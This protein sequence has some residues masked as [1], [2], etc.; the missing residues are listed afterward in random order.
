MNAT[1]VLRASLLSLAALAGP[2]AAQVIVRVNYRPPET[3][4]RVAIPV[5]PTE[6]RLKV[7]I[8]SG[9]N[10]YEHDW[11]G[12]DNMLRTQLQDT[13]R[14][15]VRVTEDF[16]HGGQGN[17]YNDTGPRVPHTMRDALDLWEKSELAEAAFGAE[18]RAHY[19][20]Y[21]RVELAAFDSAV[22]DWE[23]QRSF[24]RL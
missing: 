17:A 20:N 12:V 9:Q 2:V 3:V 24:E 5:N 15:D 23:L 6:Q 16:D 11:T 8:I 13:G 22:T 7:L 14:F 10:S 18:V 21:A 4:Q 1:K 19:A